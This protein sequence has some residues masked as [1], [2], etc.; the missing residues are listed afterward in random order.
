M[1]CCTHI[2]PTLSFSNRHLLTRTEG[3]VGVGVPVFGVLWREPLRIELVRILPKFLLLVN[4]VNKDHDTG[5]SRDR[6][7]TWE[8]GW[9]IGPTRV[10]CYIYEHHGL[11]NGI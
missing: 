7:V 10:D 3:H 9:V 11:R 5:L 1:D 4:G 8:T 6:H 2:A